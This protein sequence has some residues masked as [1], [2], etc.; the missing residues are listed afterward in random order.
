[1]TLVISVGYA[2]IRFSLAP[3]DPDFALEHERLR[4]DYVL[5]IVQCV[6]GLILMFLP[7]IIERRWS[8]DIPSRMEVVYF[9]FLY[10]AIYL[11]EVRNFYF[12]I[13]YWDSIL[14]VFSSGMLGA[15]GYTLVDTL[16]ESKNVR[17]LL[18]PFFVSLFAFCFALSMGAIWELYEFLMDFFFGTNM[19]KFALENGTLL[20]G[21]AAL[22][23]TMKDIIVDAIGAGIVVTIGAMTIKK[24]RKKVDFAALKR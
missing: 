23:D 15:L 5:M 20:I 13:P 10:C 6:L 7:A 18:S 1:M 24:G 12:V 16:N 2:I 3:A 21:Q 22:A 9:V 11:G 14:H 19:Q 8:I 17:L 4:S